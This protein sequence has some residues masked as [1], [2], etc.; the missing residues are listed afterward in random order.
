M[1][2]VLLP[3]LDGTGKLFKPLMKT[4]QNSTDIQ[5]IS[6]NNQKKQSY[7]ELVKYVLDNLPKDDFVLVAESFSGFIAYQIG[8]KK[9]KNLKH[10]ILVATF[11]QNPRPKLLKLLNIIP[12]NL[13]SISLSKLIIRKFFLGDINNETIDLFQKVIKEI[14]PE[15][16]KYRLN[17]IKNLTILNQ[18]K[19][20]IPITYIQASNDQLVLANSLDSWLKVCS[21]IEVYKVKSKHFILQIIPQKSADIINLVLF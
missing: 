7:G 11:L 16:L 5:I 12:V 6:Y 14:P 3:G 4:F 15:V 8:L 10:I 18:E 9:P 20:Q 21:N 13:F 17:L 2:L 1:K 19:I